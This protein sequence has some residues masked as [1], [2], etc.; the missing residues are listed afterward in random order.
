M[1]NYRPNVARHLK[2]L[3]TDLGPIDSLLDF[4]AGNGWMLSQLLTTDVR[5]NRAPAVDVQKR[6]Q[7]HVPVRIYDGKRLPFDDRSFDATMAVDVLHHCP[8]PAAAL[9]DA[10][11]V[12]RRFIVIKD[13]TYRSVAGFATLS[14]LDEI[15]N[16][17]FGIP[18]RYQYQ[19]DFS[20]DA[21]L[22]EEGF[23]VRHRVN[24]LPCHEGVLSVTDR[25]Q[26]GAVYER[27]N[28]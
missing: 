24:P 13:H 4:G 7:C 5:V 3:I 23:H 9:R 22:A 27:S 2:H 26:Y 16:R 12:T 21:V 10:A 28:D 20:W 6:P 15:G 19:R 17:K 14:L 18:S 11:R 25:L 1:S 8:D